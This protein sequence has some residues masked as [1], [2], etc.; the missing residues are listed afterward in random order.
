M[1]ILGGGVFP[2]KFEN[3]LGT[4]WKKSTLAQKKPSER[5]ILVTCAWESQALLSFSS[6]HGLGP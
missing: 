3:H 2:G 1:V 4:F 5:V 6:N